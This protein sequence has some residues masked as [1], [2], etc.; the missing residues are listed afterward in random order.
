MS[1]SRLVKGTMILSAAVFLSKML[2]LVFVIPFNALVGT[3][4]GALYGY[5]Y[6]PYTILLSIATL[7]V[8]LAVSKFVAKYNALGDYHTGRRLFRSGLVLMT[9]SGIIFFILLY[10]AAPF[11][12]PLFIGKGKSG[13]TIEDAT[14]VI[15]IV[16]T[17]LIIIPAMSLIRGYFQG[18][19]SMGPTASSQLVEQIVR[20]GFILIGAYFVRSVMHGSITAAVAVATFGAFVGG[21][22]GLVVLIRYWM[23]RKHHLDRMLNE[24]TVNHNI[25][26]IEMYKELIAYAIPFVAV[27]LAM[28]LYQLVDQ[29]TINHFL[30]AYHHYTKSK[31]EDV[32]GILNMYAQ[33]LIMIPVSLSTSIALTVVPLITRSF[34]ENRLEGLHKN[35]TQSLQLVLFLTVPAAIGLSMLGY[36]VYGMLYGVSDS[37]ILYLG[38][39]ILRWYSLSAILFAL[40][41]V[42]AAILQ[43]INRQKVTVFSLGV[44]ILLKMLLNPI[45]IKLFA[46]M[47]PIVATNIGYVASIFIN[48]L[49][50]K[51]QTG[52]HYTYIFKRFILIALFS[53]AMALVIQL[54]YIVT[55]GSIPR[56]YMGAIAL[57]FVGVILGGSVFA[58][59]SFRSGLA[60][61]ILGNRFNFFNRRKRQV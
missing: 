54:M 18:F 36:V 24:S 16:S 34:A 15:R 13:N 52:Y 47:G 23:K 49:A 38:G 50:I 21:L 46:D 14:L 10:V 2:G 53:G 28:S 26:L 39:H 22:G 56:H 33:K 20:V 4:G 19:E 40:F 32:F 42:T 5:A 55:G 61:Q 45:C 35:I 37:N 27:G 3:R 25:P 11:I 57:S 9:I 7:G 30:R 41:S 48:L 51:S 17:A 43:G 1:G 8:P 31:A 59:L 60:K 29:F 12:S 44:G 6:T 58:F